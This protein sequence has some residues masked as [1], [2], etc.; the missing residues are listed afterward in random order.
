MELKKILAAV[1]GSEASFK[2]LDFAA[3]LA[4]KYSAS[5][6][7]LTVV[8]PLSPPPSPTIPPALVEPYLSEMKTYYK[9]TLE[10]AKERVAAGNKKVDVRT[11]TLHGRAWEKI[12]EECS[13]GGYDLLVMG[14]RGLGG[15]RG[16]ILGSV[17][18]RVVEE[19]PCPIL[20]VKSVAPEG[21][22]P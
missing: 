22:R 10:K 17:S 13:A 11:L 3:S 8:E 6:T 18:R 1:D 9:E 4:K 16:L 21:A 15:I 19:A 2:A 20:I 7:I 14:S 12:A 5:L